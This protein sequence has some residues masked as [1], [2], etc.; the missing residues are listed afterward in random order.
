MYSIC[1]ICHASFSRKDALSRHLKSRHADLSG[2]L[3]SDTEPADSE[4]SDSD[5]NQSSSNGTTTTEKN[6]E[7]IMSKSSISLILHALHNADS[8]TH[9]LTMNQLRQLVEC[10]D[11]NESDTDE[12]SSDEEDEDSDSYKETESSENDIMDDDR[13]KEKLDA[14]EEDKLTSNQLEFLIALAKSS[15]RKVL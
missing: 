14:N 6:D 5:S 13:A 4:S 1:S 11:P 7:D 9:R 3:P 10:S 12:S 2:K 8:G 15:K